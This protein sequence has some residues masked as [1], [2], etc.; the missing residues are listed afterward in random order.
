MK[1]DPGVATVAFGKDNNEY[2]P[3]G[4]WLIGT[5]TDTDKSRCVVVDGGKVPYAVWFLVDEAEEVANAILDKVRELRAE[6]A[7]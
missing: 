4:E 5:S 2:D 1:F 6:L 7:P 3:P